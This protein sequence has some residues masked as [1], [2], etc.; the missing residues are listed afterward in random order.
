MVVIHHCRLFLLFNNEKTTDNFCPGQEV[1]EEWKDYFRCHKKVLR[2][3][4][5]SWDFTFRKTK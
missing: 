1:S 3:Y 2:N 5:L 4:L